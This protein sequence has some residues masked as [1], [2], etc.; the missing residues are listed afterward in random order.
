V[1][2]E[3]VLDDKKLARDPDLMVNFPKVE[4]HRHLEGTF[5]VPT[6]HRVALRNE[7]D[8]PAGLEEF[9]ATVQFPEDS[10]PDFLK[11][12]S[13]FRNDWYR[14]LDDVHEIISASVAAAA[15][16]SLLYLELRFSPEH[17]ALVNDFDR[18]DVFHTVLDAV[19]SG[20]AGTDMLVRNLITFNRSK[21]D[22][23]EMLELYGMIRDIDDERVVG[24]DLAG[25]EINFPPEL[26]EPFFD[27]VQR[28]GR[29]QTT[30]HAGEVTGPEQIWE[31]V[32]RLGASRIGHGVAALQD[33]N[34]QKH[35]IDEAVA[36]ELCI[37]SNY[38]TGSWADEESHPFGR[39][40]RAGVPVTLNSDDPTIQNST[41]TDDYI[42]AARYFDLSLADFEAINDR[43]IESSFLDSDSKR[44]LRARYGAAAAAFRT[45]LRD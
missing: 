36:L 24:V 19:D 3:I 31:A 42:K 35:L 33:E 4:L 25:D 44:E 16:D 6:L 13:L 23:A 7:L 43:A 12:L 2:R 39:F 28:D 30:I 8:V 21:Q 45:N 9:A 20:A 17:F 14:S 5:D 41:L 32:T 27:Q 38:Q 10:E 15:A 34:L 40:Y 18:K 11:F 1:K 29:Y 37:T 26:F 22:A